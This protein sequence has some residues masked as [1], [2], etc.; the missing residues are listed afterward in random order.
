[1]TAPALI[2]A[3]E[4]DEVVNPDHVRDLVAEIPEEAPLTYVSFPEGHHLTFIDNC[5]G[6]TDALSEARG[7]ELTLRYVVAF[8]QV[9]LAGESGYARYLAAAPPDALVPSR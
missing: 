7:H 2:M 5:L 9:H 8:L 6:C 3:G 4:K 1:M